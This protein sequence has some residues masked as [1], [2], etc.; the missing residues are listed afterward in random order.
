MF[1]IFSKQNFARWQAILS[2]FYFDIEY[3]K[4]ETNSIP[5]FLTHEFLQG[6]WVRLQ[7]RANPQN[8]E[9]DSLMLPLRFL[10]PTDFSLVPLSPHLLSLRTNP[11]K[12][13]H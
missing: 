12:D 5:D 10:P 6:R 9:P 1:K 3:N 11:K 2:V 13:P 7:I 8:L 4:G